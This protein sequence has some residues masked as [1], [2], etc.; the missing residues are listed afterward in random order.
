MRG[1]FFFIGIICFIIGLIL[2]VRRLRFYDCCGT[3]TGKIVAVAERK[4][5]NGDTLYHAVIAF[6]AYDGRPVRITLPHGNVSRPPPIGQSLRILYHPAD[7]QKAYISSFMGFWATP[8]I[9]LA[10]GIAGILAAAG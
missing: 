2:L 1:Y 4:G 9:L 8:A 10:L 6:T 3:A 5:G 7:P